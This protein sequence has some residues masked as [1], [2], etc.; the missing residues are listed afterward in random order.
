MLEMLSLSFETE[1]DTTSVVVA[2]GEIDLSNCQQL[3][4]ALAQLNGAPRVVVD[5]TKCSFFDSSCLG[6]LVAHAKRVRE[7]DHQFSVRV[8]AVGRRVID[9]TGLSEL[10]SADDR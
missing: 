9:I 4:A 10:L 3:D 6:V 7:H 8:D 1:P 2:V 5:L